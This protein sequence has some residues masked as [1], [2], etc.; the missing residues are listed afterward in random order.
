[1]VDLREKLTMWYFEMPN[2]RVLSQL[3]S[4]VPPPSVYTHLSG[5]HIVFILHSKGNV[6]E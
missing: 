3:L 2:L 6:F 4:D 1:M 5:H